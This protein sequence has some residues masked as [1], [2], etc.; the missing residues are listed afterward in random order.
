MYS[1]LC[2]LLEGQDIPFRSR[3]LPPLSPARSLLKV[4]H[5]CCLWHIREQALGFQG[6]V[7]SYGLSVLERSVAAGAPPSPELKLMFRPHPL[8]GCVLSPRLV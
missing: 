4:K 1:L 3:A 5:S 7:R 8:Y 2:F 6:G